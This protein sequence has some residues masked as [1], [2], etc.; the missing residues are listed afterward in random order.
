MLA[1]VLL[2]LAYAVQAFVPGDPGHRLLVFAGILALIQLLDRR[3]L[4]PRSVGWIVPASLVSGVEGPR[5]WGR[6]LGWGFLTEAPHLVLHLGL[7]G[8]VVLGQP[9]VAVAASLTFAVG[10]I[11]PY[12]TKLS[13]WSVESAHGTDWIRSATA[14]SSSN[15][16][17]FI[18]LVTLVCA[19][20]RVNVGP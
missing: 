13:R 3:R 2:S 1:L 19:L 16:S 12:V 18:L 17:A 6:V 8:G 11:T 20:W 14:V 5:I 10:R 15:L 7:F 4:L 9:V